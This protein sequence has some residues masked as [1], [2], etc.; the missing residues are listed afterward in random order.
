MS[1]T[2]AQTMA[3]A[4]RNREKVRACQR[5][6]YA[7]DPERKWAETMLWKYGLTVERYYAMLAA[8][9]GKCALCCK[10]EGRKYRGKRVKLSVD[11]DH[12]TL[13]VRGLL[14]YNC[15][16]KLGHYEGLA[17]NPRLTTYLGGSGEH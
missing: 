15:N 3:W 1:G 4:E 13:V 7:T 2:H 10:P 14:C 5:A 6:R 17:A 16:L 12:K 9:G 11:H 8:Q